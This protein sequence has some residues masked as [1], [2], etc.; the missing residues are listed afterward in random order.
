[1]I[2]RRRRLRAE[3]IRRSTGAPA[4]AG[5]LPQGGARRGREDLVPSQRRSA[6]VVAIYSDVD[7][8]DEKASPPL[9]IASRAAT[10]R[11]SARPSTGAIRGRG[12]SPGRAHATRHASSTA[13]S[14][15]PPP[16]RV[17]RHLRLPLTSPSSPPGTDPTDPLDKPRS[18]VVNTT[19]GIQRDAAA[20]TRGAGSPDSSICS[21]VG[22]RTLA[23]KDRDAGDISFHAGRLL[24]MEAALFCG[25]IAGTGARGPGGAA[26]G[27]G[28]T[29]FQRTARSGAAFPRQ[30]AEEPR[31][32]WTPGSGWS[33]SGTD[34]TAS[35]R[36]SRVVAAIRDEVGAAWKIM[37]TSTSVADGGR[38]RAGLARRAARR[39]I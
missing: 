27:R 21:S 22:T 3:F 7:A 35:T 5:G 37:S 8:T 16:S 11:G 15:D 34:A 32:W 6:R 1:M 17:K 14:E 19:R 31:R 33:R 24:P 39:V 13:A 18:C 4:H 12:A 29:A 23:D 25:D 30:R 36:G 10:F 9:R 38:H 2:K 20:A 28:T 26:L